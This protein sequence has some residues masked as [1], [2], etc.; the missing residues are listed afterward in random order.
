MDIL[1]IG[2]TGQMGKTLTDLCL[3]NKNYNIVAGVALEEANLDYP[4]YKS[5]DDV[6]GKFDVIIDFSSAKSLD[7]LIEFLNKNHIPTVIATTGHTE[8]QISSIKNCSKNTPIVYSGN[9]SVGVN[10]LLNIVENIS[11]KFKN[12]DIEIIEKH[13]N[14]KID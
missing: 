8:E 14:Q 2:C 3:E 13:H 9:M 4:I 5:I 7:S 1:L 12:S 11:S 10:L 6:Q